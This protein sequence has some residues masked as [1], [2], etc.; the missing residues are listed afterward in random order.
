M[1]KL[2]YRKIFR[3]QQKSGWCGPAVIHMAMVAGG[4]AISQ[5]KIAKEVFLPWWGT[6]QNVI[7]AY[8]SQYFGEID[9]KYR[10]Q[11]ADI[12][13]HL[14]KGEIIIV[15]WWDDLDPTDIEGHYSLIFDY[16]PRTEKFVVGDPQRGITKMKASEFAKRWYDFLDV[17]RKKRIDG[18]ML[19]LNP[20]SRLI[21][22]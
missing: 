19:W 8:L 4:F 22:S 9:F 15:D 5:A 17:G 20:R 18:W 12:K 16:L 10:S 2:N 13:K 3:F 7:F 6:P 14:A 21:E 1:K 11:I